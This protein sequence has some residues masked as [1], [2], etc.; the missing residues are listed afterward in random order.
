MSTNTD[1]P[2]SLV[3]DLKRRDDAARQAAL[4]GVSRYTYWSDTLKRHVAIPDDDP[5][6]EFEEE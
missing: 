3:G 4:A 1:Q 5:L 2:N 6:A